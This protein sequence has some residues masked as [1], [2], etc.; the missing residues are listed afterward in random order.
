MSHSKR[1]GFFL[2]IACFLV[3]VLIPTFPAFQTSAQQ[4]VL[5]SGAPVASDVLASSMQRVLALLVLMVIWWVTEAIPIPA[6]AL[7]PAVLLPVFHIV[8]VQGEALHEF[9]A[10]N[11]LVHYANPVIYLFLGG[12]LIAAAMQKWHLDRRLTLWILTRGRLAN[13]P[14]SVLFALMGVTAFLSMWI[15]NTATTAMMLPLG[16]GVLSSMGLKPGESRY[17]TCLML[18]IAWAASIG[19]VG[20]IIGTPPN[21]IALGILNATFEND[22]GF[23]RITF[24]DWISFGIPYVLLFIPVAWFVVIKVNPPE[25][26]EIPGGRERFQRER[27][28]LGSPSIGEKRTIFVFL[29]AVALWVS[30]PFWEALLPTDFVSLVS[31][32]D[33]YV[34]GLGVGLLLFIVPV[35]FRD[36]TFLLEWSDTR[37][38]D[39]GTL[40]LFGGGIALSDA[41]FKTGLAAWIATSFVGLLGS[42]STL[43]MMFAIVI[44]IDFL[45]EVTSNT[46]VTAMMIPIVISIAVRTG[47]DPVALAIAAAVAASMAFMLPV[48][49]PPN[50]L[51]FST[52]YVKIKDMVKSGFIL[53]IIG[54]VM[55]VG[56]MVV[57]ANWIFGV[58]RF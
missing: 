44:F 54:W 15:S 12:F 50:A 43:V 53:D 13:S 21:G 45:T 25:I 4:V 19:G 48:A 16:L 14:G 23:Q 55:T 47:E 10:R 39:W 11:A 31:W 28:A 41:M 17:G 36:H 7:L 33:E 58:V 1:I 46:A 40:M 34:I 29:T 27:D 37:F 18:G 38:V 8:G 9:T 20:T 5:Q 30:N 26:S 56:I 52:G 42:P 57:F 3:L 2:G 35:S 32:V 6:T 51:V 24:T 22:P 49:T